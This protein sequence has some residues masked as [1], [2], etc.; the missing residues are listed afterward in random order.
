MS[1]PGCGQHE[2]TRQLHGLPS[3]FNKLHLLLNN[4]VHKLDSLTT[5]LVTNGDRNFRYNF[6]HFEKRGHNY[7]TTS[8]IHN[9]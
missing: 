6:P 7:G 8:P 9:K 1:S 2:R 3:V 5:T 4:Q